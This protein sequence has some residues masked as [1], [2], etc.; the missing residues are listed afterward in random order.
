LSCNGR[1]S[2]P[3]G[4]R[5]RLL[6]ISSLAMHPSDILFQGKR[7]PVSL[8]VCNHYAGSEK[9]L[10]NTLALDPCTDE[11]FKTDAAPQEIERSS[12]VGEAKC[13]SLGSRDPLLARRS[14]AIDSVT[15][16]PNSPSHLLTMNAK[17]Q[18]GAACHASGEIAPHNAVSKVCDP[19]A[20]TRDTLKAA[21]PRR[22]QRKSRL[23]NRA[24]DRYDLTVL[25]KGK[26][27]GQSMREA[28][29]APM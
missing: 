17:M 4:R 8:P 26:R 21:E 3:A 19:S 10:K 1:R 28:A 29:G 11:P 18:I 24:S 27:S 22:V 12:V 13:L 25:R 14:V 2:Y 7:V 20:A 15:S 23:H 6:D 9:P 5:L 16:S